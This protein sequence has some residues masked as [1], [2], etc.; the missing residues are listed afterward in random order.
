MLSELAERI[1]ADCRGAIGEVRFGF[2]SKRQVWAFEERHQ[3]DAAG[4]A[5]Q[6]A[7]QD[8]SMF[9]ELALAFHDEFAVVSN[10]WRV[11]ERIQGLTS[12][13]CRAS[14]EAFLTD[15][16]LGLVDDSLA[17]RH[18]LV[19]AFLAAPPRIAFDGIEAALV[20]AYQPQD[21]WA[22]LA[23]LGSLAQQHGWTFGPDTARVLA[24]LAQLASRAEDRCQ[25]LDLLARHAGPAAATCLPRAARGDSDPEVRQHAAGLLNRS[26]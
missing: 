20:R 11:R 12:E 16:A 10:A 19:A 23:R 17:V 13:L 6:L 18:W 5:E 9:L 7:E 8:A 22:L 15:A 14:G 24:S 25:A 26:L 2:G 3:L 4:L 21:Q 1:L